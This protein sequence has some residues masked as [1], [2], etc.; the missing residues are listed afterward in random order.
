MEMVKSEAKNSES[1]SGHRE[2]QIYTLVG[3]LLAELS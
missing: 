1:I 3:Y 2:L